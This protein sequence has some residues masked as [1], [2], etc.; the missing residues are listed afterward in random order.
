MSDSL[1]DVRGLNVGYPRRPGVIEDL[2]LRLPRG[3]FTAVV[4]PN[5][6]G[7][8]TL[9]LALA[10]LL[11]P[12][13]GHVGLHGRAL[14]SYGARDL[15]RTLAFLP[16]QPLAPDGIR[17]RDLVMRGRQPY[18]RF[19]LPATT[20]D[21]AAVD[22]ALAATGTEEIAD[23]EVAGLSGGQRQ[24]VWIAMTFAQDTDVVLLDE[25]TSFLDIAH[26]VDV[27]DAGADLVRSGRSVVAVLHDLGS[28]AR[29]ADYL[30]VMKGGRLV[31]S[32]APSEVVSEDLV[33][34]VFGLRCRVIPDPETGTPLVVPRQRA[35]GASVPGPWNG[36]RTSS[37]PRMPTPETSPGPTSR[38]R[39]TGTRG[40][41]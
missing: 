6:C 3:G 33:H 32:G 1:F 38:H 20:R 26:Q 39:R 10:R 37:G 28:A 35:V 9:L 11:R 29:Y 40:W 30:V 5:G 13:A 24:R 8:S 25:P 27:L 21:H 23:A 15:A 7:K 12:A 4:G 41:P 19:L 22:A 16:Q 34:A 14:A 31:A 2:D 18:R 17:V 36:C